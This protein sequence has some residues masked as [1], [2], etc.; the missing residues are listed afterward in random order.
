MGN[1]YY[2]MKDFANAAESYKRAIMQ[3][4]DKIDYHFNLANTFSEMGEY[5]YAIKHFEVVLELDN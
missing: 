2:F 4:P 3:V 5:L 1:A